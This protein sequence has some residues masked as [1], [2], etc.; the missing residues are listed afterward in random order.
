VRSLKT[1]LGLGLIISL[2]AIVAL[3]WW[4]VSFTF[5]KITED[6]VVSRLQ[7]DIDMLLGAL[8]FD[9]RERPQLLLERETQF[10]DRPFSG[11]YY[12]IQ[13]EDRVLRSP[14]LWDQDLRF[15]AVSVGERR[16]LRST[17][18]LDQSL[19]VLA[20]GF[21]KQGHTVVVAVAEDVSTIDKDIIDFQRKYL[22]LSAGLLVLLLI[23]QQVLMRR[24]LRPLGNVQRDLQG[25]ARGDI[26]TVRDDV[27]EEI[28]PLVHEVNHLMQLLSQ[29]VERSRR[30]VGD[31][32][33]ALKTPLTVL[34][35]IAQRPDLGHHP[36][37]RHQIESQTETI[38]RRLERELSRA[39]LAGSSH[40]GTRFDAARDLPA[41]VEVLR[42]AHA[43]RGIQL[44]LDIDS[45]EP[46]PI[47]REDM[48]ELAGNVIDNACKW[49][50][51][52]VLIRAHFNN[53]ALL[54]VEDD[55]PGCEPSFREQLGQRGRRLDENAEGNGLGL[56]IVRDIVDHYEGELAFSE[57]SLGGL[58][59]QVVLA[60]R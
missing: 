39:R 20:H 29:R 56:A 26:R 13:I 36:D 27:P 43:V 47:E 60:A 17:G 38:R 22:L 42:Q 16:Q 28:V 6:Y 18:P 58:G 41:L 59:V 12:R 40:T 31:L 46:W 34:R 24:T 35:Q 19:M 10:D 54:I 4:L 50:R 5:R 57:S 55:G 8:S 1:A 37:V 11:H 21:R 32:A 33:H 3:Q 48:L 49:A 45:A 2:T 44:S 15:G 30:M 7:R 53:A 25:L 23:L 51:S 14:T 9:Y 52:Q